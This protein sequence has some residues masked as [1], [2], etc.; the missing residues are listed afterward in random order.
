MFQVSQHTHHSIIF[1][2]SLLIFSIFDGIFG[3]F[4]LTVDDDDGWCVCVCE[5]SSEAYPHYSHCTPQPTTDF[6][7]VAL[8]L[9]M[10]CVCF[11]NIL[12]TISGRPDNDERCNN[13]N[14][15]FDLFWRETWARARTSS[16]GRRMASGTLPHFNFF[17]F[18]LFAFHF[19]NIN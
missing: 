17:V 12:D 4:G 3:S 8:F 15:L 14:L 10:F 1:L 5:S 6:C 18:V 11:F 7:F 13:R 9:V 16:S 19:T 2:F